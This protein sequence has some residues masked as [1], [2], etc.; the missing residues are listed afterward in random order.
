MFCPNCGTEIKNETMFCPSCGQLLKNSA[1]QPAVPDAPEVL[2]E[3]KPS[4]HSMWWHK[5]LIYVALF[6]GALYNL[7]AAIQYLTGSVY[8]FELYLENPVLKLLDF[9]YGA[10][11]TGM[12]F[13]GLYTRS[14]LARY[15]RNG[16]ACLTALYVLSIV[17]P[18][19]YQIVFSMNAP[20]LEGHFYID[21]AFLIVTV[22][23]IIFNFFY[24]KK[25]KEL[26]VN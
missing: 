8:G 10:V 16:P 3:E 20:N 23:F 19:F 6:A 12:A 21:R 24:Y 2:C 13:W 18:V 22:A 15:K 25:R 7:Y 1:G 17:L 26:F 4:A 11:L 9:A 5:F 14:R